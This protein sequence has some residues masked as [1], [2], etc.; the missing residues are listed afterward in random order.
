NLW[1]AILPDVAHL[2]AISYWQAMGLLVLCR[3]LFGGFKFGGGGYRGRWRQRPEW[4][5][6]FM[7]MSDEEKAAFKNKWQ[8]RCG[9]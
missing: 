9:K 2:S 1:N 7:S 5:E 4:K 6:K 3:L 8:E